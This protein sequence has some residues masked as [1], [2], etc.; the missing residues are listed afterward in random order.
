MYVIDILCGAHS[1]K[2]NYI[3][4]V[5]RKRMKWAI[6]ATLSH[7]FTIF[8]WL[9]FFPVARDGRRRKGGINVASLRLSFY[10]YDGRNFFAMN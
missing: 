8:D 5:K 7:N 9:H 10:I 3:C 1:E 2:V 4:I 6:H